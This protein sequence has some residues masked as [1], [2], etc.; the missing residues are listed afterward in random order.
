MGRIPNQGLLKLTRLKWRV[1]F[2]FHFVPI[3]PNKWSNLPPLCV[4]RMYETRGGGGGDM[5]SGITD[6]SSVT[7]RPTYWINCQLCYLLFTFHIILFPWL[8]F[9]N[10]TA[11]VYSMS[12][13]DI[14]LFTSR[15]KLTTNEGLH[16]IIKYWHF[17]Y[18]DSSNKS[19]PT[20]LKCDVTLLPFYFVLLF[21]RGKKKNCYLLALN[22]PGWQ[23]CT[24]CE[25]HACR[26]HSCAKWRDL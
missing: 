8:I 21:L 17:Q 23:H 13:C 2:F 22:K 10:T 11:V 12:N 25:F 6:L 5:F 4:W 1:H 19:Y 16:Q 14:L 15:K 3:W 24:L 7:F 20:W 26:G 18:V 9:L